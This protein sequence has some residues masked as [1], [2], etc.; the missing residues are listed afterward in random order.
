MTAHALAHIGVLVADVD[1]A[2]ERWSKALGMVFSPITRY[3]PTNWSDID[4]PTPHLSDARLCFCIGDHPTIE[5]IEFT[6]TGTHSPAKGEG[7]HHLSFPPL[8]DNEARRAQL[9]MLGVGTDGIIE[10]DGRLIFMFTDARALNNVF[11]EWVEEHPDHADVKDDLSPVNRLP[12]G[13]KTLFDVKT[14]LDL[15]GD[16]PTLRMREVRI[17]VADLASS[18][19][20]WTKLTEYDFVPEGF[21]GRD[22]AIGTAP[23]APTRFRLVENGDPL[24][25]EGLYEA[26]VEVDDLLAEQNRL[27]SAGVPFAVEEVDGAV[28]LA[29]DRDY[30]SRFSLRLRSPELE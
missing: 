7:G 20:M 8:D 12:D 23:D 1:L 24:R 11:T 30:L 16:R 14:I 10:H 29:I 19:V 3:R 25:A 6:G 26:V 28:E 18:I 17:A 2:R 21:G 13:T 27:S 4:N 15:G 9:G 22:S 5:V